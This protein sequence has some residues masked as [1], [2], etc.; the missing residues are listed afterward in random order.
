MNWPKRHKNIQKHALL[1][2]PR[3][4]ERGTSTDMMFPFPSLTLTSLAAAFPEDYEVRIIDES[5]SW[6][7]GGEKADIVFITALTSTALRAYHLADKFRKRGIPVVIGGVHATLQPEEAQGHA[8]SVV[9]GEAE[10]IIRHLLSDFEKGALAP[11]YE[12]S[13]F[14]DFDTVLAPALHL[15][16]W[17]HRIF[18]SP[19]QTSRGCS[20]D[21]NFC[22]VPRIAG[23]KMRLKS[24]TVV[25]RELAYLSRFRSRTLFIVDDNF[26]LRKDR[27][28]E[29]L[30]LFQQYGFRWMAFSNLSVSEDEDYMN[31]LAESGCISL[32]IGF[33]SL[34]RHLTKNRSFKTPE[35]LSQAINIIHRHGIGIQGAFIFGFDEDTTE[36][37]RETVSFIQETG[38]ELPTISLLTPFPGTPLFKEMEKNGRILH[39]DWSNYDMN[40]VV[41]RPENMSVEELQQGYAWALKFLASPTS[42]I[43]RM[44]RQSASKA[45]FL[46]INFSLHCSQTRIA[47]GLWN[48]KVQTAMQERNLC[49]C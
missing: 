21:C 49:P 26:T 35:A 31:A 4:R 41:F 17:R 16:N 33:E 7:R 2:S 37:F 8:T 47:R 46:T 15:L 5:V 30:K 39:K 42:I 6:A 48:P 34:H 11:L 20:K 13:R 45:Y 32:F 40:H 23:R 43:A 28:L 19:L 1:I 10:Q 18:I 22:S 12:S 36:V 29:I 44:K 38:I 14:S 3:H 25:E 27:T 9:T 24:P